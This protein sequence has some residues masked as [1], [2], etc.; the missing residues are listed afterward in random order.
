MR[1]CVEL[2]TIAL[3]TLRSAIYDAHILN[4][5]T[6]IRLK[7]N[8]GSAG[9]AQDLCGKLKVAGEACIVTS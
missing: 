8:A 2:E 3:V 7:V 1:A 5:F 6:L 4:G 9:A